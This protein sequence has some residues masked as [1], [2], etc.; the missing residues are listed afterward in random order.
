MTMMDCT[1]GSKASSPQIVAPQGS[2]RT[3]ILVKQ[4]PPLRAFVTE[5]LTRMPY[6]PAQ[7][8][9]ASFARLNQ[10]KELRNH[11][12]DLLLNVNT[13]NQ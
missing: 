12:H 3:S 13:P 10:H 7:P 6:S 4:N 1:L 11:E 9:G 8:L 2:W 5:K